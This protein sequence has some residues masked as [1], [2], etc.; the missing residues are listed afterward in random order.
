[1]KARRAKEKELKAALEP[2]RFEMKVDP[3]DVPDSELLPPGEVDICPLMDVTVDILADFN[4]NRFR[5][6]GT[7]SDHQWAQIRDVISTNMYYVYL[8]AG[9]LPH[10]IVAFFMEFQRPRKNASYIPVLTQ[11][12]PT[13]LIQ[14]LPLMNE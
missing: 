8:Q 3:N 1:M 4:L 5:M 2:E 13:V 14:S 7:V 9:L 12:E 10:F 6:T 11:E